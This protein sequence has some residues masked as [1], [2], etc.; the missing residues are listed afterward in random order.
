M[1]KAIV[2]FAVCLM[3]MGAGNSFAETLQLR[4]HT[5]EAGPE[6]SYIRYEEPTVMRERGFMFG[7]TA[8]YAYHNDFMFKGEGHSSIGFVDY[9]NSGTIDD[10]F[11][12]MFEARV[13][14]GY[15]IP[16]SGTSILTPY[17][18]IG[19]RYLMDDA[20]GKTSS[21][22]AGG[23][24]RESNYLYS[25]IGI[26]TLTKLEKA[27][28]AGIVL[29]YDFF[30]IGRQISHYED[31][32]ANYDTLENDQHNGYGLRGS[33]RLKNEG[34]LPFV[35]EP[36]IRYW[37]ILK[38]EEEDVIYAGTVVGTGWEPKNNSTEIGLKFLFSF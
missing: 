10:I 7:G 11:N 26:E 4:T 14:G 19:Y 2:S 17:I 35:I 5:V 37:K 18:G 12:F 9:E 28:Y 38:S 32:S 33:I 31:V 16:V 13:L 24:K 34:S 29:E 22:G 21:T 1:K 20:G 8:S 15:D 30:W 27:W 6:I 36:F 23:Y 3:C 25:P